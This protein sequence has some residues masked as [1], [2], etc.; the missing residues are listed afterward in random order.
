M[1]YTHVLQP[2]G[3]GVCSLLDPWLRCPAWGTISPR[4]M[5]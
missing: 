5:V 2:G 4:S 1:V 3:K